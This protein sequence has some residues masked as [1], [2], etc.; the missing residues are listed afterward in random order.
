MNSIY[1]HIIIVSTNYLMII[2]TCS[3]TSCWHIY[4]GVWR[5]GSLFLQ[6]TCNHLPEHTV[7]KNIA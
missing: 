3:V 4:G 1:Q 6:N 5:E 2:T 7:Q